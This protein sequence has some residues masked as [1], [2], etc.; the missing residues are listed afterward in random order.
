MTQMSPVPGLPP[1]R[2]IAWRLGLAMAGRITLSLLLLFGAYFFLPA[3][4]TGTAESDLV[5]LLLALGVFAVVVGLQV[6]AIVRARYPVLRAVEA[7]TLIIALYLLIFARVYLSASLSSPDAFNHP[8]NHV[9]ALY[10]TVTVFATVGFGDY[11]AATDGMRGLVTVQM[12]LN[13][14]VLGLIIRLLTS[15]AQRGVAK[16][17]QP[18]AGDADQKPAGTS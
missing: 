3:K 13:L 11:V 16:K 12:V 9:T 14:I 17:H 10:F 4:M 18:P 15:A 5:Y 8:L 1:D 7:L 6:P 2:R